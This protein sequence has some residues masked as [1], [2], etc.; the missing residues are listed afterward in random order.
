MDIV[1]GATKSVCEVNIPYP[2]STRT[3]LFLRRLHHKTRH[4]IIAA[5]NPMPRIV[6]D[7]IQAVVCP[8]PPPLLCVETS[9]SVAAAAEVGVIMSIDV[10]GR[11][12]VN[13]GPPAL[14]EHTPRKPA[15]FYLPAAASLLA[16][17]T[18]NRP[19]YCVHRWSVI[20]RPG[21]MNANR[22]MKGIISPGWNR[23]I[24]WNRH[25]VSVGVSP[26]NSRW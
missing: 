3:F 10:T 20:I 23:G 18:S 25:R 11:L 2:W 9:V 15:S 12:P 24:L 7:T 16:V 4:A 8:S 22:R 19:F 5:T 14:D 21:E 1:D 26:P 13:S 17:S 6:S